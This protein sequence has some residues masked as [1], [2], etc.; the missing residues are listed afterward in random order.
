MP[1]AV[2]SVPVY[3]VDCESLKTRNEIGI[4]LETEFEVKFKSPW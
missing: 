3:T 4:G 1:L 2:P